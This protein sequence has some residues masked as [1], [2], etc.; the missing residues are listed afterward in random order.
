M[1]HERCRPVSPPLVHL[2]SFLDQLLHH[3]SRGTLEQPSASLTSLEKKNINL[4]FPLSNSSSVPSPHHP[5]FLHSLSLP[6]VQPHSSFLTHPPL[7]P[8]SHPFPSLSAQ[9]QDTMIYTKHQLKCFGSVPSNN[10]STSQIMSYKCSV[11][12]RTVIGSFA[13][14]ISV[15]T[16]PNLAIYMYTDFEIWNWNFISFDS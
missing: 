6:F 8:H 9:L 15:V 16:C 10:Y 11:S 1:H 2:C 7:L 5:L 12:L 3:L 4:K 14:P 13:C